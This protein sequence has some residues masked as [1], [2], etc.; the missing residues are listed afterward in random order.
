MIKLLTSAWISHKTK[1]TIIIFF[2]FFGFKFK[3]G[4]RRLRSSFKFNIKQTKIH[5]QT[6]ILFILLSMCPHS[7]IHLLTVY[8]CVYFFYSFFLRKRY[9]LV[10]STLTK[11]FNIRC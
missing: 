8:F 7:E 10:V 2:S 4:Y 3:P 6:K 11:D 5:G 9:V 1:N